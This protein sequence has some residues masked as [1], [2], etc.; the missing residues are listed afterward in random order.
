MA[1]SVVN[2]SDAYLDEYMAIS[3]AT[4]ASGQTFGARLY[5]RDRGSSAVRLYKS[6]EVPFEEKDRKKLLD[7]N[8]RHLLI[9]KSDHELYQQ[10]LRDNLSNNLADE[11]VPAINRVACLGE[12]VRDVM[13]TTF[14]RGDTDDIVEQSNEIATDCVAMLSRDD[15]MAGELVGVLHHDYQTFTH[16]TN[17]AFYATSLAKSIGIKDESLLNE[18][19]VGG[20]LHDLGKLEICDSILNKPGRLTEDE[21]E[22]IKNHPISGFRQLCHREDL[23]LGQL[24]MVY[25]HH[26]KINGS[27]YPVGMVGNDIH[28]WARICTVVDVYEAL[29]SNRPYR[30]AIPKAE[31]IEMMNRDKR[32]A[33]DAEILECWI[34]TISS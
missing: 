34:A 16:S 1:A 21:F 33:F 12:V 27:G 9:K 26:E 25:Q 32:K 28:L 6:E 20:F 29:T 4:L 22:I 5:I 15:L 10:Y 31:V 18:I 3:I 7:S 13:S 23:S 11:T 2:N 8:R 19:V 30:K 14:Y 17:V 24:M